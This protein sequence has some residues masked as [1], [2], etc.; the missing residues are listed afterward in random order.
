M[1]GKLFILETILYGFIVICSSSSMADPTIYDV[2]SEMDQQT[3]DEIINIAEDCLGPVFIDSYKYMA[4]IKAG[5]SIIQAFDSTAA[6]REVD[7]TLSANASKLGY[8]KDYAAVAST[9]YK[10]SNES[11]FCKEFR[12]LLKASMR[13]HIEA[14]VKQSLKNK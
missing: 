1:L 14:D 13:R 8:G 11:G 12:N 2:K 3:T 5:S 6:N 9:S 4:L 7:A 10:Y